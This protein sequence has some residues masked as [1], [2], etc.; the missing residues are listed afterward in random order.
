MEK[1]DLVAGFTN[2]DQTADPA[3]FVHWL[4]RASA[5]E[6][7]QALKRR[8]FALL[9]VQE[10]DTIL[11]VGCGNGDDVR[12]LAQRVGNTGRVVG[13]D[14]SESLIAEAK[15]RAAGQNLPVDYHVGDALSLDFA[16]NSFDG[17]RA[18]R[19]FAYLHNPRQA[20]AEII[21]VARPGAPIVIVDPDLE[22]LV[23]DAPDRAITRKLLNFFCDS[24]PN[25]WVGRQL[26]ALFRAAGL[27][28]VVVTPLTLVVTDYA[29]ADQ[30]FKFRAT[31]DRAVEAGI[32]S[33]AEGAQWLA[34]LEAASQAGRFSTAFLLNGYKP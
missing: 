7:F 33:A 11:D 9:D 28:D 1:H 26:P 6:F 18:E 17:C 34:D 19:V 3:S 5:M 13:V 30:F 21:R 15:Q 16:D 31:V 2:V 22:A 20:L 14:K 12:T 32:V 27:R 24:F 8:T 23:V 4:D 10:G 25:A 29:Q